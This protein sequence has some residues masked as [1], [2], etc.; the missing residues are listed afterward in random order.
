MDNPYYILLLCNYLV[1]THLQKKNKFG[2]SID[3][4]DHTIP[5]RC[6]VEL[7]WL[8]SYNCNH[9]TIIDN[10]TACIMV[11]YGT[12]TALVLSKYAMAG[13]PKKTGQTGMVP[14]K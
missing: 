7:I 11:A 5:K 8:E 13:W 1:L 6:S 14:K 9:N 12:T 4:I 2:G 3:S 10:S